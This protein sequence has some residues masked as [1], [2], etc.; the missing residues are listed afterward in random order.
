[1]NARRYIPTALLLLMLILPLHSVYY[2]TYIEPAMDRGNATVPSVIEGVVYYYNQSGYRAGLPSA[3][4]FMVASNGSSIP[5][6][7]TSPELFCKLT[8]SAVTNHE[9]EFE[10]TLPI[11][12]DSCLRYSFYFCGNLTESGMTP[13][14][15]EAYAR[16]IPVMVGGGYANQI[17]PNNVPCCDGSPTCFSAPLL[18]YTESMGEFYDC[19]PAV[20]D[21]T[22]ELCWPILFILGLLMVASYAS[23]KNPFSFLDLTSPRPSRGRP[24][25]MKV[26][27]MSLDAMALVA[28][29]D[30]ASGGFNKTGT[31]WLTAKFSKLMGKITAPLGF[32]KAKEKL[33]G[34]GNA[35]ADKKADDLMTKTQSDTSGQKSGYTQ[36]QGRA[37]AGL[38]S[39]AVFLVRM[40]VRVAPKVAKAAVKVTKLAAKAVAKGAA[41]AWKGVKSAFTKEGFNKIMA[42]LK[43]TFSLNSLKGFGKMFGKFLVRLTLTEAQTLA[44]VGLESAGR[45]FLYQLPFFMYNG[46]ERAWGN[47]SG[48]TEKQIKEQANSYAVQDRNGQ[49]HYVKIENLDDKTRE[50]INTGKVKLEFDNATG[51]VY[52]VDSS[53]E[54]S[55]IAFIATPLKEVWYQTQVSGLNAYTARLELAFSSIMRLDSE[56]QRDLMDLLGGQAKNAGARL[57][58]D[59]K[60]Q[61]AMRKEI[62]DAALHSMGKEEAERQAATFDSLVQKGKYDQAAMLMLQTMALDAGSDSRFRAIAAGVL[63]QLRDG[64]LV[65]KLSE[66]EHKALLTALSD[67]LGNYETSKSDLSAADKAQ[68]MDIL[69]KVSARGV[70]LAFVAERAAKAPIALRQDTQHALEALQETRSDLA[71]ISSR[72]NIYS[73]LI[74]NIKILSDPIEQKKLEK[75]MEQMNAQIGELGSSIGAKESKLDGINAEISQLNQALASG[76]LPR[77]EQERLDMLERQSASLSR[78]VAQQKTELYTLQTRSQQMATAAVA[79][80]QALNQAASMTGILASNEPNRR[81][82]AKLGRYLNDANDLRADAHNLENGLVRSLGGSHDLQVAAYFAAAGAANSYDAKITKC[83]QEIAAAQNSNNARLV[84]EKQAELAHLNASQGDAKALAERI[85]VTYSLAPPQEA[86]AELKAYIDKM[87]DKVQKIRSHLDR[88]FSAECEFKEKLERKMVS[89]AKDSPAVAYAGALQIQ[90]ENQAKFEGLM[91][92]AAALRAQADEKRR[93]AVKQQDAQKND[94]DASKLHPEADAL[95]AQ[96]KQLEDKANAYKARADVAGAQADSIK[97][98][99]NKP[100]LALSTL[101]QL[102]EHY[103]AQSKIL[104]VQAGLQDVKVEEL[105]KQADSL[106]A[107]AVNLREQA[108]EP[109]NAQA[110]DDLNNKAQALESRS[111]AARQASDYAGMGKVVVAEIS[112]LQQARTLKPPSEDAIKGG[113]AAKDVLAY[114]PPHMRDAPQSPTDAA[115]ARAA[116]ALG[117]GAF[118]SSYISAKQFFAESANAPKVTKC[119]QELADAQNSNDAKLV[120]EKQAE[121]ARLRAPAATS[122]GTLYEYHLMSL[123]S[124]LPADAPGGRLGAMHSLMRADNNA[125]DAWAD[126]SL[127]SALRTV[128]LAKAGSSDPAGNLETTPVPLQPTTLVKRDGLVLGIGQFDEATGTYSRVVAYDQTSGQYVRSGGYDQTSG[129]Y[130]PSGGQMSGAD[131]DNMLRDQN[132]QAYINKLQAQLGL[133]HA[134][135]INNTLGPISR[136]AQE[137]LVPVNF[138][139]GREYNEV[140]AQY[141][142]LSPGMQGAFDWDPRKEGIQNNY[143]WQGAI[144]AALRSMF[145]GIKSSVAA[146]LDNRAAHPAANFLET[147]AMIEREGHDLTANSAAIGKLYSGRQLESVTLLN[148]VQFEH[149]VA[150]HMNSLQDNYDEAKAELDRAKER[151]DEAKRKQAEA[152]SDEGKKDASQELARAQKV[153]EK[154]TGDFSRVEHNYRIAT[155]YNQEAGTN[156]ETMLDLMRQGDIGDPSALQI[157]ANRVKFNSYAAQ[158]AGLSFA[159]EKNATSPPGYSADTGSSESLRTASDNLVK[160]AQQI[161]EGVGPMPQGATIPLHYQVQE[162]AALSALDY[163]AGDGQRLY[164]GTVKFT[165]TTPMSLEQFLTNLHDAPFLTNAPVEQI[166]ELLRR[167]KE[168][169]EAGGKLEEVVTDTSGRVLAADATDSFIKKESQRI[170]EVFGQYPDQDAASQQAQAFARAYIDS[171]MRGNPDARDAMNKFMADLQTQGPTPQNQ[172]ISQGFERLDGLKKPHSSDESKDAVTDATMQ[173]CER[174][175]QIRASGSTALAQAYADTFSS[176]YAGGGQSEFSEVVSRLDRLSSDLASGKG[177]EEPKKALSE[178]EGIYKLP[179]GQRMGALKQFSLGHKPVAKASQVQTGSDDTYPLADQ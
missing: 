37:I 120:S 71:N 26:K 146:E 27:N 100:S 43:H 137:V 48:L 170:A 6:L 126:A 13:E 168:A 90:A 53:P 104:Q 165:Q 157:A 29:A 30:K 172:A 94:L 88:A 68:I 58:V 154:E 140:R 86:P 179:E 117:P 23:G 51:R 109:G 54:G 65:D 158:M 103:S 67:I 150:A 114:S 102:S 128:V 173:F 72:Q 55:I 41:A 46:M 83:E 62:Y 153:L 138:R 160:Q 143:D 73:M 169:G 93:E 4:V 176:A 42:A 66:K 59:G 178:L 116:E 129:Q 70:M 28:F 135:E 130:V 107:E 161:L 124:A 141:E 33:L 64:V 91:G 79:V 115:V 171:S 144:Q 175:P 39:L 96:A 159:A 36:D 97:E 24:Y 44:R 47:L 177:G 142:A 127:A 1:M 63:G 82:E 167:K 12:A 40:V 16:C 11:G 9:G 80:P 147:I 8:A 136:E 22:I 52:V 74:E 162:A 78:E 106:A 131:F 7:Y 118:V 50:A 31:G 85:K 17:N 38:G 35:K 15:E 32:G 57:E 122:S 164:E 77:K 163:L 145:P 152:T 149:G 5:S 14:K 2:T 10:I 166:Q 121:L 45:A 133:L 108:K 56:R 75:K 151:Y 89:D 49:T 123:A 134:Q 25:Q 112:E 113:G 119:E 92:E 125:V 18:N 81:E 148:M 60:F 101:T 95:E 76:E 110:A 3:R 155:Q 84:S 87:G 98:A 19:P 111:Q 21:P 174:L 69:S 99:L 139:V 61:A 156:T 20:H 132:N 34:K 105:G